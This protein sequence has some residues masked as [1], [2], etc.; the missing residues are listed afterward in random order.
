MLNDKVRNIDASEAELIVTCDVSCMTQING[1]LSRKKD[2]KRVV[3]IAD[4]LAGKIP[5]QIN[6]T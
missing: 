6:H 5:D 1:G 3:H 2:P 4:V